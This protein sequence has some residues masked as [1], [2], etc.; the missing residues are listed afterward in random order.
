MKDEFLVEHSSIT[1]AE[2]SSLPPKVSACLLNGNIEL[3]NLSA[4]QE[5]TQTQTRIGMLQDVS[6][7]MSIMNP[8]EIELTQEEED[9]TEDTEGLDPC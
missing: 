1:D 9:Q 6:E 2:I 3:N 5:R 8:F 7:D 4:E